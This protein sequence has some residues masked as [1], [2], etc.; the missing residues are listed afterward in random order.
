MEKGRILEAWA[1]KDPAKFDRAVGHW[2]MLRTRLQPMKKK[3]PE[4]YEVMYNVAKCL[5]R[6]A[7][8]SNDKAVALDRAKK[9][10]Q[11][12][13]AALILSPKLNGPDTVARYKVLLDKAITLQGRSPGP[14]VESKEATKS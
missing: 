1:E 9:A 11:V 8:K 6:E 7:E 14:K 10:E 13:K 2:A 4:Y 3:P 12:L 5:V